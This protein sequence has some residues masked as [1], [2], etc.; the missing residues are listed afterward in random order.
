MQIKG[1]FRKIRIGIATKLMLL[2]VGVVITV[3]FVVSVFIRGYV[4]HRETEVA[5]RQMQSVAKMIVKNDLVIETVKN[6][7]LNDDIVTYTDDMTAIYHVDFIVVLDTD[8]IRYSHPT[9]RIIGQKFSN[10][11][12]ARQT[13]ESG[14]HF[15]QVDG[16]LG[17]GLRF[18]EPILDE[19]GE[20]VGIVCVGYRLE[21]ID[22]E[23]SRVQQ[24]IFGA[25]LFGSFLAILLAYIFS[26][27]LK[28]VLLGLEPEELSRLLIESETVSNHISE[29][30][31]ALD[32]NH[33]ILFFNE[34]AQK[35]L[36]NVSGQKVLEKGDRL[37]DT[38]E[39][40]LFGNVFEHK[41]HSVHQR[42]V[43]DHLEW[44]VSRSP[45][46][47]QNKFV[48]ALITVEDQTVFSQLV[49]E[50]SVTETYNDVLR[51]ANHHHM[52]Q[53]HV[54]NG[55]LELQQ[56]DAVEKFVD[57]VKQDYNQS[58]GHISDN[59]KIPAVTGFLLGKQSEAMQKQLSLVID[60]SSELSADLEESF[61]H[62]L[63][64]V[65][66]VLID[67][68]FEASKIGMQV[69]VYIEENQD[70]IICIVED[71][72]VGMS[73]EVQSKIFE[74]GFSTKGKQRGYGLDAVKAIVQKRN[75]Q[76]D[77]ASLENQGTGITISLAIR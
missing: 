72:G 41:E 5:Q 54:I 28:S 16:T 1:L 10:I 38:V 24:R 31:I 37:D 22:I 19:T 15:S 17:A 53:M 60:P 62:D 27:W 3:L 44:V 42:V 65:L 70:K 67:N 7:R 26:K 32:A 68:A 73:K 71:S 57:Y 59:I 8:F 64:L 12:D 51:A 14:A 63:T 13:L 40:L 23:M 35:L 45:I 6:R 76:I 55:L 58:I 47:Q 46:Y 66:G 39:R 75:G 2:V 20:I 69:T 48:G 56:Y 21:T 34:N 49:T 36:S 9:H 33:R 50:L 74:R 61:V 43:I 11:A 25:V 77:V 29:G 52:N 4:V 18:F 30:V